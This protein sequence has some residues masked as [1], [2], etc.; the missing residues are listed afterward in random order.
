M[1]TREE[2]MA[3]MEAAYKQGNTDLAKRIAAHVKATYGD[4]PV[5][6]TAKLL[7]RCRPRLLKKVCSTKR[8][9]MHARLARA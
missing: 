6:A 7:R 1:A 5:A 9:G 4:A 3:G 8:G 2:L